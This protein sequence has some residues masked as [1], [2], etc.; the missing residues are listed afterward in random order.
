MPKLFFSQR[1]HLEHRLRRLVLNSSKSA[2]ILVESEMFGV[3]SVEFFRLI[4]FAG[5]LLEISAKKK[6][7]TRFRF[8]NII[9]V[10]NW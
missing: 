7:F 1:S 10:V 4:F 5:W 8:V 6:E 9:S 3:K 2:V